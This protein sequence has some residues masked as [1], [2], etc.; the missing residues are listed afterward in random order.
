MVISFGLC[1]P[2]FFFVLINL[3]CFR[4]DTAGQERYRSLAPIYYRAAAAALVVYDITDYVCSV[5]F[6]YL[7]SSI[8][9]YSLFSLF[10]SS[11]NTE[12]IHRRQEL[13]RRV[14]PSGQSG[15]RHW[16]RRQ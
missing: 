5:F 16:N 8:P 6:K 1:F 9:S 3:L 12:H 4:R 7:E 10:L 2:I 11:L 13:D 14:A 15:Y